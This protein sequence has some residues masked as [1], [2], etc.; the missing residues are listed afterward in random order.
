[1]YSIKWTECI[2]VFCFCFFN[3]LRHRQNG[4]HFTDDLFRYIC[5]NENV[6]NSI[7][8]PLNFVP[9]SPINN[10][11]ALVQIMAWCQPGDKPLSETM[12]VYWWIFKLIYW[13]IP[14][15]LFSGAYWCQVNIYS[16]IY[17][18]IGLVPSG[19]KPLHMGQCWPIS[20]SPYHISSSQ[21]VNERI[22]KNTSFFHIQTF[23]DDNHIFRFTTNSS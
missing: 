16:G 1:M 6:W 21:W 10:I 8:I 23:W 11:P 9:R 2:T 18:G 4:C 22:A 20:M 13:W 5:L 14:V 12:M 3:S 19:S 7:T 15:K 17:S